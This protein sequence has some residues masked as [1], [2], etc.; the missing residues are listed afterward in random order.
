MIGEIVTSPSIEILLLGVGLGGGITGKIL[1]D[2]LLNGNNRN[3]KH[4]PLRPLPFCSEHHELSS[5]V[6]NVRADV[7]VVKNDIQWIC[8]AMGRGKTNDN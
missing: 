7:K 5:T 1:V 2:R 8:A 3:G 4:R 6:S